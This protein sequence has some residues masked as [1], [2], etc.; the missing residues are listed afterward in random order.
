MDD[1][2]TGSQ[3]NLEP[4]PPEQDDL[5]AICQ[6]LNE[7]QARYLVIGGFAMIHCGFPRLTGDIDILIDTSPENEKAVFRALESLPDKA[8]RELDPGDVSKYVVVRVADEI[9]V[10]LM[11]SASGITYEDASNEVNIREVG[12]VP[13][14]FASPRLLWRMKVNTHRA[15]DAR[16]LAFLRGYFEQRSEHPPE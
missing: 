7:Q 15:K 11:Q 1:Q 6:A 16:D 12:G 13:I 8:V 10:D 9:V 2:D 14:P 5:A 3:E 4:R